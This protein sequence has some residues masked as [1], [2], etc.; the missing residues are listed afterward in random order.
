MPRPR[1]ICFPGALYHIY[2][3][4]NYKQEIFLDDIDRR[5]FLKLFFDAKK[6]FNFLLYCYVLMKNHVHI[7]IETPNAIPIS[8]IM[9]FTESNYARYFNKKYG[10]KGHLF[11]GR[12]GDILV[13]KDN[14]LLGLSRYIHLN[15]V[16]AEMVATPEEYP[17]S[18]YRAYVGIEKNPLLDID[19]ILSYFNVIMDNSEA[20]IRYKKF[21]EEGIPALRIDD[22]DWLEENIIRRR[23]LGSIGFVRK[24]QKRC[25]APF[26]LD[27]IE[28]LC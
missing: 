20:G 11:Q 7:T 14:Y 10:R 24:F 1:R 13:D 16:K 6:E 28:A 17:W 23:F 25:Q 15:P 27:G 21:V 4:G 26:A 18:S 9:Y 8:K 2:Q 12:F 19:M 5:F 22:K 3:R